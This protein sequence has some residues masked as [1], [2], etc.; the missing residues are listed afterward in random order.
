AVVPENEGTVD[1]G[2]ITFT[3][4]GDQP[5][6]IEEGTLSFFWDFIYPADAAVQDCAL[7]GV[8]SV[9]V[10]VTPEDAEGEAFQQ[11]SACDDQHQGLDI[12]SL[13]AGRYTLHLTANGSYNG[14]SIAL[15][16]SGD[17]VVDIAGD[18]TTDLGN[19]DMARNDDEFSDFNVSWIFGDDNTCDGNDS[20]NITLSFQRDGEDTPED[21]LTVDCSAASVVR[22]TFVP[23]TY[24]VSAVTDGTVAY[25]VSVDV[26]L[27]P[28]SA[29]DVS[30]S[31]VPP[32]G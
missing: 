8:D 17:I 27:A 24:T 32:N 13:N 2:T 7:A 28:N 16:D 20:S 25:G 30:L 15:Y 29:A 19:I 31:L 6:P 3:P 5:P 26:D 21:T 23:G 10:T 12:S 9:D 14:Q 11:T 1:L 4:V 22:R 18:Q